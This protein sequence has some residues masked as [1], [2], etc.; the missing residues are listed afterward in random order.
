MAE[1]I[2]R[3]SRAPAGETP[4]VVQRAAGLYELLRGNAVRADRERRM[5]D[6]TVQGLIDAGI[7]RVF[8]PRRYGGYEADLRTHQD[9]IYHL[10][11]GCPSTGWT[12]AMMSAVTFITCMLGE[13]AQDEMF[14]AD[15]DVRFMGLFNPSPIPAERVEG[16]YRINGVWRFGTG[17]LLANWAMLCVPQVDEQGNPINA[18]L[19]WVPISELQI[20]DDWFVMGMRGTASN[21]LTGEN[22]FVPEHRTVGMLGPQGAVGSYAHQAHYG[23]EN[24]LYRVPL[25]MISSIVFVPCCIG[26]ARAAFD[27]VLESLPKRSISYGG[28]PIQ[29]DVAST[30][31]QMAEAASLIDTAE[32][33][34]RRA[35]DDCWAAA[36]AGGLP[37]E[38]ARTRVRQDTS[39]AVRRCKQAV[40]TLMYVAGASAVAEANFLQQLYRDMTTAALHGIARLDVTLELYGSALCGISP[41][42]ASGVY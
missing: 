24:M 15:P 18:L 12:T 2:D 37:S 32:L 19:A 40:D 10:S 16:G 26:I 29:N 39:Y 35:A 27:L 33:H 5:P 9:V 28:Y 7:F 14:G 38:V 30:Q 6:E 31:M 13:R 23:E 8:T 20:K 21:T 41:P 17:C 25:G 42:H 34:I 36:R 1:V 3:E 4:E 22:L 11:R